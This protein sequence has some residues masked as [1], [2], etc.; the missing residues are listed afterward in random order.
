MSKQLDDILG[1]ATK[2]TPELE[3][4][5]PRNAKAVEAYRQIQA[6]VPESLARAIN[7]KAAEEGTTG[8]VIILRALKEAGFE[9]NDE[10]LYDQRR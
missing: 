9:I 10:E 7:M 8:R 4:E 6:R 3:K 2:A 5:M 1:K